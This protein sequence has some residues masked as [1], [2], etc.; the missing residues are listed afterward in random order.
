MLNERA[1]NMFKIIN[2]IFNINDSLLVAELLKHK[3]NYYFNTD[4]IIIP[5]IY[6]YLK[7]IIKDKEEYIFYK[8]KD[9]TLFTFQTIYKNQY[10]HK[11]DGILYNLDILFNIAKHSDI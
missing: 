5:I 8:E 6:K 7:Y 11:I 1:L 4:Y 9:Y 10:K 3:I 2:T